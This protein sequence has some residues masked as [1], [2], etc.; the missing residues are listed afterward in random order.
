AHGPGHGFVATVR[1]GDSDL[2]I[3][4]GE[5]FR[6]KEQT[7]ALHVYVEDCDAT[8]GRALDAGA[9]TISP[10]FGEPA[11]RPYAERAAFVTDPFGNAWNIATRLGPSSKDPM[12]ED[13]KQVTIA[14]YQPNASVLIDFLK[15]AFGAEEVGRRHEE[16][17]RLEHAFIRIGKVLIEMG[18][19]AETE[20]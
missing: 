6:G 8:Y 2:L 4:G 16:G 15:R 5:S 7:T 19:V 18:D 14:L 12:F 11:D 10:G 20:P 13:R 1:I 9:V 3:F 17:G